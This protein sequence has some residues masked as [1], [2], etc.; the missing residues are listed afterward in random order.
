MNSRL[1]MADTDLTPVKRA[2]L[3]IRE[4]RAELSRAQQQQAALREPIAI[5]GM[6]FRFPG[7]AHDARSFEALLWSGTDAVTEIP[8]ERWSLDALYDADPD[9][10]GKMT[11]RYGAFVDKVDSFD[12][13]FFGIS[14]REAA[15]MDPQQRLMLEVAWTALEDAGHAGSGLAGSR[16]GVYLG[17]ANNDYGRALY[18]HAEAIDAYFATGNA[19]SVVAGRLA[20]FLGVHGPAIA[21]DTACSSSLVALHLA[22]QG[23]RL[24]ECDMALAGG[25][26]LILTPEM[27]INFSKASM[28]APDGR[29]KTF[30][31]SADGYVRGEGCGMLVLRRLSDARA[32]GD[33][34]LAVVR[35]SALNQDGRSGGLTAPNGP[36]QEAVIR[37]ALDSAGVTGAA[38]G[39]V[40]THGTGTPLGDPIEVGA[41]AAALCK[42]RNPARP[43]PIGSVKTNLGHLEAA[44]GVASVVKVVLALQRGEIPPHLH[45]S[46]GNPH[47]DWTQ[48]LRV[49][50]A[51]EV[52]EPIEGRRLAGVSSF[53]FSGTNAH[54]IIEE[55]PSAESPAPTQRAADDR[56]AHLLALSA[57]DPAA[58]ADLAR[59]YAACLQQG[60]ALSDLCFTAHIGRTHFSHR[61]AV[62]GATRDALSHALAAH[63]DGL[64]SESLACDRVEGSARPQVAFLFTGQGAQHAGMGRVLYETAP[65]FR[66]A[67]DRCARGLAAHLDRDLIELLFAPQES[68]LI[69][70]TRYAQPVNFAFEVALAELWRSWGIEPVAVLGHSLGEYAAACVAGMLP[71]DD[72]LRLVAARGRLTHELALEGA[73]AAVFADES[74]V[75][76]AL[77]RSGGRLAI[78]AY[79]GPEH[80]VLSGPCAAVDDAV[81]WLDGTGVR[82]KPIR[83]PH[84]AHSQQID[85]VLPAYRRVLEA[86]RFEEP[87]ITLVSNVTGAAAGLAELG[88][89]DYWIRHMREPVHFARSMGTLA[90]QGITHF[91]EIGPHPVLLG[92]GAECLPA[93]RCEWLPSLRRDRG[94]GL[95]LLESLQRLYVAGADIDWQGFEGDVPHRRVALPSYPFRER[96]HWMDIIGQPTQAPLGAVQRWQRV[97]EALRRQSA[98]GPL[99]LNVPSYPDKWDCLERITNAH[100]VRT[101]RD[102]GLFRRGGERHA[103]EDVMAIAAVA[104]SYRHLIQRWLERLVAGGQLHRQEPFFVSAQPLADPGLDALWQEAERRFVDN[105]P[106]LDYVRHCGDLVGPVL[107]GQ[108]S[109]LETLFP[110]GSEDL[111]IGLYERSAT[112]RYINSL[113]ASAIGALAAAIPPGRSLRV[114]EVGAGTGG[115][116]TSLLPMLPAAQT[117]YV[118]SDVSE[119]FLDRASER[120]APYTFVEYRRF[121][122]EQ[123]PGAQGFEPNSFDV[124][125]SAN[126]VHAST[127]LRLALRRLRGLLAPGGVMMLV[128]STVHLPWFDM[129][130]G[131]IEGWQHFADDL[132]TDNPLLPPQAWM[133]ALHDAGF[134]EAGAWPLEGSAAALLGQHVLVARVAG[135][136]FGRAVSAAVNATAQPARTA[137]TDGVT[138]PSPTPAEAAESVHQRIVQA[139]PTDRLDLLRDFVRDRVVRVLR[140]D[141]SEPPGRHDR[142]MDLGFDS[143]M[144]VQLRNQLGKGLGLTR[145]LPATVMFDY[146]TIDALAAHLLERLMPSVTDAGPVPTATASPA[147]PAVLGA[148]KVAGMS[149]EEVEA[150]LMERLGKS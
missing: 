146:P 125:V 16:T 123:D 62:V 36:A 70:E 37:A 33:R 85:P 81:A 103:L 144:A 63:A 106:L 51:A 121:D 9:A 84:G 75:Q 76:A 148:S 98:Q 96:H 60:V 19:Y 140:L 100:A 31:A 143:L 117:R 114:L 79:N 138:S 17:V 11:T 80:F 92:M 39:Y 107:R 42:D 7:G 93:A 142:L 150:L 73:M 131:L 128:E 99:D 32:D 10:P 102:A 94:E 86:M 111:A 45:F 58:L 4:L 129:T 44:A 48:P 5:V 61:L 49:P 22:I 91:I 74:V 118:F 20:Y 15:T 119:L 64:E 3:E 108:E 120:F 55:A 130:T 24:R 40:E 122:M 2:L 97:V 30:D 77:A 133:G 47:I 145:P 27:N 29:C 21:V 137:S 26:N 46:R 109:P 71:L 53:G 136:P 41:L 14:P 66:R 134:E 25:V 1:L 52:W 83:V 89:V 78:A 28:M 124:I 149:E 69:N 54:V 6:G 50:T 127:D 13:E 101:L 57:R 126:A 65:V 110:G 56:P 59:A 104:P 90:A 8:T 132:R 12:A 35:G 139:L 38:I 116:T 95:D 141:A 113:A 34:I 87:R 72:G 105:Q 135:E 18:A 115:T 68:S 147:G 43:L 67:L 23:L 112:M 88:Q 82:V